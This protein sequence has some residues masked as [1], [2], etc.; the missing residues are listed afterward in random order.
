MPAER[1]IGVH[2]FRVSNYS[3][4]GV[5]VALGRDLPVCPRSCHAGI[6][7]SNRRT[8]GPRACSGID[9]E[10]Q[11]VPVR[12]TNVRARAGDGATMTTTQALARTLDDLCA[13]SIEAGRQ[14]FRRAFPHEAQVTT[15]AARREPAA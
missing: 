13:R 8:V 10:F 14:R 15:A 6:A 1:D 2:R 5:T 11:E 12:I 3:E 4:V 9:H 7:P